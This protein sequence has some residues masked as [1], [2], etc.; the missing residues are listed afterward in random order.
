ML[1]SEWRPIFSDMRSL[2]RLLLLIAAL[3]YG[4]M[5]M[6]GMSAMAM[7]IAHGT[8]A[9]DHP[10]APVASAMTDM[11]CP[12]SGSQLTH[13]GTADGSGAPDKPMKTVWHCAACLTLPADLAMDDSGKPARAA[14]APALPA[15]LVSQM[16]APVTPPPRA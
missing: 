13:A 4:A 8:N 12:H 3:A 1:S 6:T 14:E 11:D 2:V 5:P 7:P 10:A 9:G 15:R 16:S